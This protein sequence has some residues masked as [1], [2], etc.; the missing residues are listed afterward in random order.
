MNNIIYGKTCENIR[1]RIKFLY[2]E[3]LIKKRIAKPNFK[4]AMEINDILTAVQCDCGSVKLNRPIYVGK[5]VLDLSKTLMYRFHYD[6]LVCKYRQGMMNLLFTDTDSLCYEIFTSDIYDNMKVDA[7]SKYDFSNY[8]ELN[9]LYSD[10]NK[11]LIVYMKDELGGKPM[12]EFAGARSICCSFL[13]DDHMGTDHNICA[14]EDEQPS[15]VP[16]GKIRMQKSSTKSVKKQV[17]Y[18]HLRH[19]FFVDCVQNLSTRGQF[20]C[21]PTVGISIFDFRIQRMEYSLGINFH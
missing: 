15:D 21:S 5:N 8:D 4:H 14:N 18:K 1:N 16:D 11:K 17:K 7:L 19:R 3:K 9:P 2:D 12:R 13:F 10:A 6:H 20:Q